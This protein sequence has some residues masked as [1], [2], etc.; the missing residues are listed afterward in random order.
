M[1]PRAP[2]IQTFDKLTEKL[3]IYPLE[4]TLLP[5]GELP[6][7]LSAPDVRHY[8]CVPLKPTN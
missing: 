1:K 2:F 3:P 7:E 4:N 8:F 5:G 6:L